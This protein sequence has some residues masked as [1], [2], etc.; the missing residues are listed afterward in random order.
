MFCDM[1]LLHHQTSKIICAF[2]SIL[3]TTEKPRTFHQKSCLGATG[4]WFMMDLVFEV[5][6]VFVAQGQTWPNY[7][8]ANSHTDT[9]VNY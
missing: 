6:S 8:H 3:N 1:G 5:G 2:L 4:E 7:F 9:L